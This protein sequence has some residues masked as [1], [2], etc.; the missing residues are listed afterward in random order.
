[1]ENSSIWLKKVP[2]STKRMYPNIKSNFSFYPFGIYAKIV[3]INHRY[4]DYKAEYDKLRKEKIDEQ[5]KAAEQRLNEIKDQS[6]V[7]TEIPMAS[8]ITE[9]SSGRDLTDI[10]LKHPANESS[11]DE[12]GSENVANGD[13][14]LEEE[15]FNKFI[16]EHK[17]KQKERIN[18]SSVS[19]K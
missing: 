10:Y 6:T 19:E 3:S 18:M 4:S 11:E 8:F 2:K 15:N 14:E 13:N 1:M 5:K 7:G 17:M 9:I 12:D 16:N